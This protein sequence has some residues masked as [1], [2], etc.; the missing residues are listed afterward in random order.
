MPLAPPTF[1]PPTLGYDLTLLKTAP[2]RG[3]DQD[4]GW[5]YG[6]PPG[7]GSEQWPLSPHDGF[8]MQHCFTLR[9]PPQYR[10]K[11]ETHVALAMFA[12]QQY[13][14][15][16]E[17]DAVAQY[18]A[19]ETI[20][21]PSDPNLLPYFAY[22]QNRHPMEFRMKDIIDHNFAAIW[23]TET[24]FAGPLCRPPELAGNPLLEANS[25]PRWL[26]KGAARTAFDVNVGRTSRIDEL[27]KTYWYRLFGR[28]PETGHHGYGIGLA[29]RD[30]D[31]NV[32]KPPRDH[33]LHKGELGDYIAP[34]GEQGSARGLERLHGRNH[35]GG[36]MFPNQWTPKYSATYL[37]IEEHFGGFNFGGG[38]GQLDLASMEFDW[39]CG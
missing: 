20:A 34:Y 7:I 9:V 17:I 35:L 39:A 26:V 38:N 24:E 2:Q 6:L 11:G 19:A 4:H 14:E 13:D 23:L 5:C 30:D 8:P 37:E 22:R 18:L 1:A 31:P 16:V 3:T 33:L 36:T 28:I 21:R 10:V 12:D 25:P 15:P 27:E 29:L 32:G